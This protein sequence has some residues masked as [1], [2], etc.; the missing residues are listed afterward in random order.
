MSQKSILGILTLIATIGLAGSVV[1]AETMYDPWPHEDET[2]GSAQSAQSGSFASGRVV[3]VDRT[4]GKVTLE[5][6]PIPQL[7][8]EGGTRNFA[9]QDAALLTS[10]APG[11]KV[12][13]EVEREGR[14][15]V[16]RRIVNSN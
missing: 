15:F 7:L 13:F 8:L 3:A 10:L 4:A 6:P 9:V 1:A 11:D 12:R 16:V 5:Y 2:L 14:S